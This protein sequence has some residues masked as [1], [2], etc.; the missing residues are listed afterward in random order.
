MPF[1]QIALTKKKYSYDGM[2][3]LKKL[4]FRQCHSKKLNRFN[5]FSEREGENINVSI[6]IEQ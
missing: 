3:F 2:D 1:Y 6:H 5:F 4:M